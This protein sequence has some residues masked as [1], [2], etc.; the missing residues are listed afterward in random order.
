MP[1]SKGLKGFISSSLWSNSLTLKSWW[2]N[3]NKAARATPV[4]LLFGKD[5]KLKYIHPGP[6]FHPPDGRGHKKCTEDYKIIF[7]AINQELAK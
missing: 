2:L 6:E 3:N 4:P 1:S 7:A 5:S